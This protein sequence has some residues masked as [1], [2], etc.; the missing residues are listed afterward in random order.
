MSSQGLQ[1]H[2]RRVSDTFEDIGS[3]RFDSGDHVSS[4]FVGIASRPLR[5]KDVSECATVITSLTYCTYDKKDPTAHD[6]RR[7]RPAWQPKTRCCTR[8]GR[9]KAHP[10][11]RSGKE[12]RLCGGDRRCPGW[13]GRDTGP[14]RLAAERGDRAPCGSRLSEVPQ[15]EQDGDPS[16]CRPSP[17]H[18]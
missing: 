5:L 14:S 18:P 9:C 8:A 15:N 16:Y 6:Q 2:Q 7:S 4:V 3:E 13:H 1:A 10:K 11:R 12:I 17:R